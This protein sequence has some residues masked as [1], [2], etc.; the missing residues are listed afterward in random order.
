ML[1]QLTI[2]TYLIAIAPPEGGDSTTE[3]LPQF[4]P[5]S[6]LQRNRAHNP[7]CDPPVCI[8][9]RHRGW[10]L[11]VTGLSLVY[12]TKF[13][14][15]LVKRRRSLRSSHRLPSLLSHHI[16]R[17]MSE[18]TQGPAVQVVR[19]DE[20]FLD[21]LRLAY[22]P[23]VHY[24]PRTG[25]DVVMIFLSVRLGRFAAP[26]P[27]IFGHVSDT[28]PPPSSIHRDSSLLDSENISY[29]RTLPFF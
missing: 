28:N 3:Y 9:R 20:L 18:H 29:V 17:G 23:R 13:R 16:S 6:T 10:E 24:I 25:K 1:I 7:S 26:A 22:R 27:A 19:H 21:H 2:W 8:F 4:L 12:G 11:V 5:A 15:P 14:S